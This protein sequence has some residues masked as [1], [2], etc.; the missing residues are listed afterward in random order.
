MLMLL[1]LQNLE[2]SC[3]LGGSQ[4]WGYEHYKLWN[5]V[6]DYD[7]IFEFLGFPLALILG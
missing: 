5:L 7:V 2:G 1:L 4:G 6:G 3:S